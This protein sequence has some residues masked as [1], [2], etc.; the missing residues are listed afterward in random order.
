MFN[1]FTQYARGRFQLKLVKFTGVDSIV[2]VHERR[3][4]SK[5][6]LMRVIHT[7]V[8]PEPGCHQGVAGVCGTLGCDFQP[9]MYLR[10][11]RL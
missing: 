10:R 7:P 1:I 4:F 3:M 11:Y 2:V 9:F 8:H 5:V 6:Q